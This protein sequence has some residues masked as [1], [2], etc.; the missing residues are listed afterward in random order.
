MSGVVKECR[1]CRRRQVVR[2]STDG[3]GRL[4]DEPLPCGCAEKRSAGVCID[5]SA[6]PVAGRIGVALRCLRC[7]AAANGAAR[8]RWAERHPE[9]H[10][11]AQRRELRKRRTKAGRA[12]RREYDRARRANPEVRARKNEQRRR[13]KERHPERV[14][15]QQQRAN[16][17]RAAAK[18]LHMHQYAT[19]Y[20]GEGKKPKCACGAEIPWGGRG[21]P[22]IKCQAC[23]PARWRRSKAAA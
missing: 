2:I 5:C 8:R 17:K 19:V 22:R 23:G 13:Y 3:R 1:W 7:K 4:I 11:A 12:R 15:E 20:V 6:A 14:R 18:R 9:R 21:R 10:A 16:E